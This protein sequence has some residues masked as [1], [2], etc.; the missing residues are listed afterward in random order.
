MDTRKT[1]VNLVISLPCGTKRGFPRL[2][3]NSGPLSKASFNLKKRA[4]SKPSNI[5]FTDPGISYGRTL[6]MI[7]IQMDFPRIDNPGLLENSNYLKITTKIKPNTPSNSKGICSL[8]PG[9]LPLQ[10]E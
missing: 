10:T 9:S 2:I 4:R 8:F 3:T 6:E 7:V 5:G 1:F